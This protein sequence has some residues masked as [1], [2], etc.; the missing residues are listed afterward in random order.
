[1][2]D[3][4]AR[5]SPDVD[6]QLEIMDAVTPPG[7]R[8]DDE[9]DRTERPPARAQRHGNRRDGNERAHQLEPP[10]LPPVEDEV[11]ADVAVELRLARSQRLRDRMLGRGNG[12]PKLAQAVQERLLARVAMGGVRPADRSVLAE[13]DDDTEIGDLGHGELGRVG[14]RLLVVERAVEDR[15]RVGEETPPSGGARELPRRMGAPAMAAS[16]LA[17]VARRRGHA[18]LSVAHDLARARLG[19]LSHDES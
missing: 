3:R 16:L 6:G 13:E 15:A 17:A 5:S 1:V 14:E 7:F 8:G 18:R 4:A 19:A 2:V 10:R 11:T 12:W 9:Q